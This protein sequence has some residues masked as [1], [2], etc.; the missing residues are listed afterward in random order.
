MANGG[1]IGPT[2]VTSFG[3]NKV[4]SKTSS[5]DITTQPGTRFVD[6]LVVAGGGGGGTSPPGQSGGGGA[7]GFRTASSIPV[8]GGASYTL[9][10]GAGG[11]VNNAGNNSIAAFPSNP[12][13]SI[14]GGKGGLFDTPG[15]PPGLGGGSGGGAGAC[16]PG[17]T[18]AGGLGT[19]CQGK[20]GGDGKAGAGGGGG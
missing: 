5:G 14:G 6:T 20:D 2:N 12:I 3:K 8:C 4:T 19:A 17:G 1:I 10:V 7:G 13:T 15:S 18:L 11:A 9:T 16:A